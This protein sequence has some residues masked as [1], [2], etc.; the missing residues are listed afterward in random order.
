MK[1]STI[2]STCFT[3]LLMVVFFSCSNGPGKSGKESGNNQPKMDTLALDTTISN[4]KWVRN[5][6]N[7][8]ENKQIKIFGITA[9]VNIENTNF[10]TNGEIKPSE[11]ILILKND[12]M[13]S[14]QLLADF[15]M[16]RLFSEKS[17]QAIS[18]EKFPP[19][20]LKVEKI[21]P[22]TLAGSWKMKGTL[23]I[24]DATNKVAFR[25][26]VKHENG[27]YN[28]IAR[29]QIQTLDYPIREN[30]KKENVI[31]DEINFD[32][33]LNFG[34]KSVNKKDTLKK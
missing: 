33:N 4:I 6:E 17:K 24:K 7:K 28:I 12:T 29:L 26:Q 15:M 20:L 1:T 11:G 2:W 21:S 13:L 9:N 27:K 16:V 14:W 25:S 10:T 19:T 22:D 18:T 8:V 5:V 31:K 32:F 23:T 34:T 3:C 30:V